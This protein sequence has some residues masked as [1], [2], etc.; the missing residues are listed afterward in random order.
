MPRL[1][2]WFITLRTSTGD[3]Y[4][5]PETHDR[6]PVLSGDVYDHPDHRD[7]TP[8]LTSKVLCIRMD[9]NKALTKSREYELGTIDPKWLEWC[10]ENGY[11]LDNFLEEIQKGNYSS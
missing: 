5:A 7:G 6:Y 1:E 10:E 3:A 8:V 11:S 2:N 4:A 9:A